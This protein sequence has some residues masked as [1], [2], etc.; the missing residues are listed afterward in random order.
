MFC[1][2]T[3]RGVHLRRNYCVANILLA[4]VLVPQ[5]FLNGCAI[6][7]AQFKI[8]LRIMFSNNCDSSL[9][10]TLTKKIHKSLVMGNNIRLL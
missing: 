5:L 4:I 9:E 6:T 10:K 3:R 7:Q 2:L 8:R 1:E